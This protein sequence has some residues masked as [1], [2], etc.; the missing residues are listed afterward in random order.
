[1]KIFKMFISKV[2]V[3]VLL[4]TLILPMLP[5]LEVKAAVT[6]TWEEPDKK[7]ISKDNY[8][9]LLYAKIAK[10]SDI[11]STARSSWSTASTEDKTLC[12]DTDIADIL[13]DK[14][15][16]QVLMQSSI[17]DYELSVYHPDAM[18][19]LTGYKT[20]SYMI[21]V[22]DQDYTTDTY[23][24]AL[25]LN[26]ESGKI[27]T[28]IC[29]MVD[30]DSHNDT[31]GLYVLDGIWDMEYINL[32]WDNATYTV[33]AMALLDDNDITNIANTLIDTS[34]MSTEFKNGTEPKKELYNKFDNVFLN[35]ASEEVPDSVWTTPL[36]NYSEDYTI[37][38]L[39]TRGKF[40]F[41][42]K[43]ND[44]SNCFRE[45][46]SDIELYTL[47]GSGVSLT[48][49]ATKKAGGNTSSKI[50]IA[51]SGTVRYIILDIT[52]SDFINFG[53]AVSIG[54][55]DDVKI[56]GLEDDDY[57]KN[58]IK[59]SN[60]DLSVLATLVG[61]ICTV[62]SGNVTEFH[63]KLSD[64]INKLPGCIIKNILTNVQDE[65]E[66]QAAD[67]AIQDAKE[68][69]D[70]ESKELVAENDY[71]AVASL[72]GLSIQTISNDTSIIGNTY[73]YYDTYIYVGSSF[74]T[75]VPEALKST[76]YTVKTVG[77]YWNE[78][79]DYQRSV[80]AI[81]Y[82]AAIDARD[83]SG[84]TG[85][86]RS[87]YDAGVSGEYSST[88]AE[89][90]IQDGNGGILDSIQS[91]VSNKDQKL[92]DTYSV[93][94]IARNANT[95][96]QYIVG[97]ALYGA[98]E[99]N[100]IY[101]IYD[102]TLAGLVRK[103]YTQDDINIDWFPQ[104]MPSNIGMFGENSKYCTVL[105]SSNSGMESFAMFLYNVSYAFDVAAFSEG[106][107][108][109]NY[110][111]VAL[112][113]YFK[114]GSYTAVDGYTSDVSFSWFTG[115]NVDSL[116]GETIT[117]SDEVSVNMLRSIIELHDLCEFLGI[118]EDAK[119]GGWTDAIA[120]YLGIYDDHESFFNALRNNPNIYS[121]ADVGVTSADEPLG[122]FFNIEDKKMSDQ[123]CKGFAASALY[124][125]METN[126]YDAASISYI[127]DP[128]FISDF[129][130]KYAFYRKALYINTDNSAI[131]NAKVSGDVSGTRVA[132][133][134][135]LLNYQ[136]DIILTVDDNFYNAKDINS[137]IGSLDYSAVRN[138]SSTDTD[139]GW[140]S[141]K[142]WVG[143][144]FDLSP[145]QILKTG[146]NSY[147]SS[148]LADSVT[149]LGGTPTLTSSIADVYL[150]SQDDLLGE[151]SVFDEYEYSVKQSYGVV[152]AVYRSAELY[153]ECLRALA[154][155]N[156]IFKSSKGICSTPGTNSSDWRSIYNYCML[157]NLEEQMKNDAASTLDLDAPIF[158]DLFGNIVTESGLV[159]IPAAANATLCGTNWN[160][161]T[162][163][164]SEY[165]NNGNRLETGEFSDEVYQ[166]LTGVSYES[167]GTATQQVQYIDHYYGDESGETDQD[168]MGDPVYKTY[169]ISSA[170][171]LNVGQYG[172]EV[173]HDN[174]GGYMIVDRSGQLMLRTSSLSGSSSSAII[175][176]ENLN[177][178]STVVKELFYNDAYFN[179]AE[180]GGIYSKTLVNLVVETLRGAPI[181]YIDY[182]YEGISGNTD[183]SKFGVYMAYKLEELTNALISGTNGNAVGGNALITMPNLA[184]V[185]GI[186]YIVLYVFK[187]VFALMLVGLAI[188]LY[189]DAVK[190]HLGI[191]SVGKFIFTCT[192]VIV[193][194]TLVP[195]LISWSYYK[196]NKDLLASESG[197]IMM[198]NY[199]KD[200]DGAE[201][202]ITNVT[203]PETTTELYVKLDDVSV[204]WW[205]VIG[206][207]LFNNTYKT[208]T[209]L[210]EGQLKDNAMAMQDN[211]QLKGDGLYM[212][213]Q[214]I[215]DSTSIVYY[216]SQNRLGNITYSNSISGGTPGDRNSV[217]S[218]VLPYYVILDK[219]V[220][221]ID[222]YNQSKDITAY[223]W[224][225]G[226]NGHIMTY[227]IISPY[228]TSS[229]FLDEGFDIL[230]LN[231]VL[232]TD[233]KM[234]S[235][236]EG[237]FDN[238]QIA[239]MKLSKWYPT[240]STK[241]QLTQDRINEIYKYARDYVAK[242]ESILGKIPDEVFLKVFALQLSIK[243]NQVFNV[244]SG[245]AIE[246][247]NIDTRDIA[248]LLVS[249]KGSVYKYYSYGFARFTYEESGTLG[250]I[251]SALY[252]VVLWV[253][254]ILKPLLMILILGLLIINVIF[255]KI[256]FR[257]ESRCVEGYFIGC[258][259]LVAC[260]YAYAIM[261][262]V[263]L[264]I[265]E[266]GFGTI[267][268]LAV[269]LLVQI[270]YVA[271][272]CSICVI[273]IK[274]WKN[275]GFNEFST[276]GASITS[277]I[278]HAQSVIADKVMSRQNSAYGDAKRT[279][280]Y[281]SDSYDMN[282]VD[283][284]L[285]RDEEREE[286][287]TYSQI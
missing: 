140:E 69:Y 196:A 166:W 76:G 115:N 57:Y 255:R 157:A 200:Y 113:E 251:F 241:D 260:N 41:A 105:L 223:S 78:L 167:N 276:I 233:V 257:K 159:I 265:S 215:F 24:Y 22:N 85:I 266:Y 189:L 114:S 11:N 263:S 42:E 110:D 264:S 18:E 112:R 131:V 253:T 9:Y 169:T 56:E 202:G 216:P 238:S 142:N 17:K 211:V 72:L 32:V 242:N 49:V 163:G 209:E 99:S 117:L 40:T 168:K 47:G 235:Y 54:K 270:L 1:M 96:G 102:S 144:L 182:E 243:F 278:L 156:A 37:L 199:V 183:I 64:Y 160:P 36:K 282:S 19:Y 185:T 244:H 232:Q 205:D 84:K 252:F 153:N 286:N 248:R 236:T 15:I 194:I 88:I 103:D 192:L 188:S 16:S 151:H 45:N 6:V 63:T 174:A 287:G 197:Y 245:N 43:Q 180:S 26:K 34:A 21:G 127:N 134:R 136:R 91:V 2:L 228:L 61:D 128:D 130:Y 259:C 281:K 53:D 146:A 193:A 274:D 149:K 23:C 48:G 46:D 178:N 65:M 246:I 161:N 109:L 126:L 143:D 12:A 100:S 273:E 173:K 5:T 123:W 7:D 25:A 39:N 94:N 239:R 186:E 73:K 262:K 111:P 203:T 62:G 10:F 198:L 67:W 30:S 14:Y 250:V 207:V 137:V 184:F 29:T 95:I 55:T 164:W 83:L 277:N 154:S 68:Y 52:N 71:E 219:L 44:D 240:G 254:S 101:A 212:D 181:E 256:L 141:L 87:I 170:D 70:S 66:E 172:E 227:D 118:L 155:D 229:E 74:T 210:Y 27:I 177:K 106:G 92:V 165:Y 80:L 108:K 50:E 176:W 4:S 218:F 204:N 60:A 208:V 272:L 217:V 90:F 162:V 247:M 268:A 213:V 129:Y 150:L 58:Y 179:K 158:C 279:R 195:N 20:L 8:K 234:T 139:T 237:Y 191:K 35:A 89:Q 28:V 121:R 275:N 125:P 135:D 51:A 230:G 13:R 225:V 77:D 133:L 267:A 119:N 147:Y 120:E 201:I 122:V 116:N 284:M 82:K 220:A 280:A 79:N 138:G 269:A 75:P 33:N 271:G 145:E 226:S 283:E 258:A 152:S 38:L 97:T 148:T 249:D 124:V 81:T 190:N 98:N 132:T 104:Y 231:E 221:N 93:Y 31:M 222:E 59:R 86:I 107:E 206:E 261:L 171:S 175:Q 214:D 285:D 3:L 224:S 187:V